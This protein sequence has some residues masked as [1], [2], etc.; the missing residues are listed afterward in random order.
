MATDIKD[1]PV[2]VW[3]PVKSSQIEAFKYLPTLQVLFIRFTG[4]TT[5]RYES[6]PE[7]VIYGFR[8]AESQGSFFNR[9]IKKSFKYEKVEE[10]A[11]ETEIV[12]VSVKD[13]EVYRKEAPGIVA[14]AK[15]ISITCTEDKEIAIEFVRARKSALSVFNEFYAKVK[16]VTLT[17][18]RKVL[19]IE[20]EVVEPNEQAI[21][22]VNDR[23]LSYD[24]Q[25]EA[26]ARIERERI[27]KEEEAKER[28]RRDKEEAERKER[29][30]IE[31]ETRA[32]EAARLKAEREK[33]E[34]EKKAQADALAEAGKK[35][36]AERIRRE[37]AAKAELQKIM[38]DNRRLREEAARRDQEE[39]AKKAL[40]EPIHIFVPEVKVEK[41]SGQTNVYAWIAEVVDI[42]TLC[43]GI[44]DGK[45]PFDVISLNQ[46]KLNALAK[47]WKEKTGDYHPGVRAYEDKSI[48]IK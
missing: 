16:E 42:R 17:A 19:A 46:R 4:G 34:A 24:A 39:A 14:Q 27:R 25:Q 6:V 2:S 38:D 23:I 28:A 31:D 11:P 18:H 40:E 13:V 10:K 12:P 41:V 9:N 26:L 48:R 5:Y 15:A 37:T 36:E 7:V 29:Q 21:A 1:L 43:R 45:T 22:I 44:A 3:E 35:D 30:R 33:F 20:K 8:G 47:T 32:K